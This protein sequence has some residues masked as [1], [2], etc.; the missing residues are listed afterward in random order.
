MDKYITGAIIKKLREDKKMTQ[1]ELANKLFVSSKA[2]SK[3]ERGQGFPDISLI[4]ALARALDISVIELLSGAGIKNYN[5]SSNMLKSKFYVCPICG[6]VIHS[7]GDSVVS[8]CGITLPALK[9]E[10]MD[11]DHLIMIK[12]IEDEY[13]V[14][15]N[16]PMEKD[17]YISFIASLSE[18]RIDLVKLYPE[19]RCEGRFKIN[20]V[21]DIYIYCNRHGFFKLK[22]VHYK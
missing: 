4:E 6:N 13:Y 16:H 12:R 8:C 20:G 19:G 7:V 15:I 11:D 17:H 18:D 21:K 10:T 3:W 5:K 2:I 9:E 1:E 22:N 14:Y